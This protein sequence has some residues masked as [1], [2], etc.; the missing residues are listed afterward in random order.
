MPFVSADCLISPKITDNFLQHCQPFHHIVNIYTEHIAPNFV[1]QSKSLVDLIAK[2]EHP[3]WDCLANNK[4]YLFSQAA[5]FN[6]T[7]GDAHKDKESA[8]SGFDAIG[9]FGDYEG[10]SLEFPDCNALFHPDQEILS[11]F[12]GLVCT[13]KPKAGLER[14]G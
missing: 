11:S 7:P 2:L 9:V 1:K 12:E 5:L 10:G 3:N 14:V 6:L 8:W 13:I 4:C